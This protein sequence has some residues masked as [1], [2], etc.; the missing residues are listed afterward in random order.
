MNIYEYI[1]EGEVIEK[2]CYIAAQ[3]LVDAGLQVIPLAYGD[4]K[5][6]NIKSV[7]QLR[8]NP[9]NKHNLPYYFDRENVGLGIMLVGK[10]EVIDI[11]EKQQKG[12][13]E[14]VLWTL[15]MACPEIY[16][17]L[18]IS[19]SPSGG[20]HIYYTADIVG[21]DPSLADTMLDGKKS[22]KD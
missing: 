19:R 14:K 21:G 16:E 4:K 1:E 2:A 20:A 7:T 8:H 11:D 9:L 3:T 18:A 15:Q 22:L 12:I 5:P 6:L 17:R 10:M 13:T